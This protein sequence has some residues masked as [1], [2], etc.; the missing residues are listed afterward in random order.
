LEL[1]LVLFWNLEVKSLVVERIWFIL[2]VSVL[3]VL[4][5]VLHLVYFLVVRMYKK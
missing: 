2:P 3:Y 1:Y 4:V 5:L